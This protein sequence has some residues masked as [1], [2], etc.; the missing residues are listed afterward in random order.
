MRTG[1]TRTAVIL[2]I[3]AGIL[4]FSLVVPG[5]CPKLAAAG[6]GTA[7]S[8]EELRAGRNFIPTKVYT[9][10]DDE[11]ILKLFEG[12]RVADVSDGM[13]KVGLA[14]TGLMAAYQKKQRYQIYSFRTHSD[15]I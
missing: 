15:D 11:R 10:E 2:L 13:D 4:G 5:Y 14:N 6:P 9:A 3:S 7:T 8:V 1:K 12:L